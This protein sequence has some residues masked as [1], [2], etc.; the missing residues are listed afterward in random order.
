M[1]RSC[2]GPPPQL[3]GSPHRSQKIS[4]PRL[5]KISRTRKTSTIPRK[6]SSP[7]QNVPNP[8]MYLSDQENDTSL[9]EDAPDQNQ[10]NAGG[11]NNDSN[12]ENELDFN[13]TSPTTT[14][15][16]PTQPTLNITNNPSPSSHDNDN[17]VRNEENNTDPQAHKDNI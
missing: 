12:A 17:D 14:N 2:H 4:S 1:A 11:D 9:G 3:A 5:T 10:D 7:K 15:D 13:H 16:T 8:Q 6:N